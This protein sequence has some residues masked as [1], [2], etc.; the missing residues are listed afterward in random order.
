MVV[1]CA[2]AGT[3]SAAQVRRE[4]Y[5]GTFIHITRILNHLRL[6][7]MTVPLEGPSR[8]TRS[9]ESCPG[10]QF[11]PSCLQGSQQH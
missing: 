6:Q 3:H 8:C 11:L 5:I 4:K 1:S 2:A 7:I 9:D 10:S